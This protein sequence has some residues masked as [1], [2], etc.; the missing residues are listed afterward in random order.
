V[1][2]TLTVPD[3]NDALPGALPMLLRHGKDHTAASVANEK[4]T[5]EWPG[6][7]ITEY[8]NPTRC[9]LF[10]PI[11]DANPFFHYLEALWIIRGRND[12]GFL[13]HLLPRMADYSDDGET[14]HGA[15]G[16]R[17]R[18]WLDRADNR[19]D[20]IEAA[21]R[22]LKNKPT[23]RQVVMSIW[24]P[25]ADLGA[26][27]KDM[28]CNDM[29]MLKVRNG[30]LNMTVNNRSNDSILGCYGANAVQF[31][32]LL[33]YMA[34]R[35]G[36]GV[37]TYHQVSDS[38]HVYEDNP[39]WLW[40]KEAY[41]KNPTRWRDPL[42]ESRRQYVTIGDNNLFVDEHTM[43]LDA[44]MEQFFVRAEDSITHG[45]ALLPFAKTTAI[46]TATN[47]WNALRAYRRGEFAEA[48]DDLWMIDL[49]D[50]RMAA[51]AWMERRIAKKVV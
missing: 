41:E 2:G 25:D 32:M 42:E 34:A 20:Q 47:L 5:I 43:F 51:Q 3:I 48:R 16:Y 21:I 24:D 26:K 17:L 10:D 36:V 9:V 38:F 28:P 44:E 4:P 6:L 13:K 46:R 50:W 31:S 7:W 29:I 33:M 15:Y 18:N 1:L 39:Y 11:R 40:F 22:I 8:T 49:S 14:F 37:G 30:R 27:T 19:F 35:I 12:V 45:N 23:S